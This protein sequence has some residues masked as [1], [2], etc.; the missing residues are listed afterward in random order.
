L[1]YRSRSAGY[2]LDDHTLSP[3]DSVALT[4]MRHPKDPQNG[5]VLDPSWTLDVRTLRS[6]SIPA[7]SHFRNHHVK[8]LP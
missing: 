4:A 2:E 6:L 3:I 1:N 8:T 7:I 5:R